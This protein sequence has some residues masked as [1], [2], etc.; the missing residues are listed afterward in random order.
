MIKKQFPVYPRMAKVQGLQGKVLIEA[1]I[2]V[3][4]KVKDPRVILSPSPLLSAASIDCVSQWEYKPYLLN[5]VPTEV[6][7]PIVVVFALHP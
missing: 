6:D 4:G 2:G 7:I 1:T 3:D 5:G